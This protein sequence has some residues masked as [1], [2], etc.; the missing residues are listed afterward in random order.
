[1]LPIGVL[2]LFS[3]FSA[4]VCKLLR[5]E[6]LSLADPP[7][8]D[9]GLDQMQFDDDECAFD[10]LTVVLPIAVPLPSDGASLQRL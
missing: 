6:Q 7:G 3:R 10:A 9:G 1:M 4:I 8:T 5:E 2:H